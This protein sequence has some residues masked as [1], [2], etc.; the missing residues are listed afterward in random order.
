[1]S[2][3]LEDIKV[4][5][6]PRSRSLVSDGSETRRSLARQHLLPFGWIGLV[7]MLILFT[8]YNLLER[9]GS[10][11]N[12]QKLNHEGLAIESCLLVNCFYGFSLGIGSS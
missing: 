3:D 11:S 7:Y 8:H 12:T 10:D 4:T 9:M 2:L 5:D 1:M 6:E